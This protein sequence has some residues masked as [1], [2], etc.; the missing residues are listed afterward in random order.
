MKDILRK[1]GELLAEVDAW[2]ASCHD[3]FPR[4][5][6]CREGC[7]ECCRGLF[8]I[9]LLDAAYLKQGFDRL[10]PGAQS[11][12]RGKALLRLKGMQRHW[13]EFSAPYILNYRPEEE[14]EMLMPE[15]DETQCV[16]LGDDG[17]C[18]VYD[19]RPMTC[20]LNG[21]PHIDCSGEVL[22]DE[23]CTLN[24]AATDPLRLEPLRGEFRRTFRDE[25]LL[26][27]TLVAT[28]LNHELNELDTFIP[29]ALL[30][31]FEGFDW[32]D[33]FARTTLVENPPCD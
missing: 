2:F 18:L 1:Y 32:R 5:I 24:F 29:T 17:R 6:A 13:P 9:T 16:L 33:W 14:W 26:F 12:V 11:A 30:L 28:L 8:D 23:W 22:F 7:S 31:D 4:E 20:R 10:A 21:I 15:E 27:R 25:L 19:H 3:A